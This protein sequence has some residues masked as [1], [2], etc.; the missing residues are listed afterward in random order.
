MLAMRTA[1]H[2]LEE[3]QRRLFPRPSASPALEQLIEH[4]DV[5]LHVLADH[6]S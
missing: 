5:P 1:R 4:S 3:V 6:V 2:D